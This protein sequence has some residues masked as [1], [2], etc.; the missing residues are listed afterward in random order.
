MPDL[1]AMIDAVRSRLDGRE[2]EVMMVLGSGLGALADEMEDAVR[3]AYGDI[4]GFPQTTVVGHAG[5][6]VVGTLE[7]VPAA[8]LQ[9]RFHL[10]EGHAPA[11]AALPVRLM[12]GLGARALIVTNAAGALNPT[13]EAGDLMLIDDHINLMGTNPLMGG[14]VE[15]DTRFPDM[16]RAYD[17]KL[18]EVAMGVAAREG[19]RLRRGV[20]CA[21]LGP[22]YETPA[23]V[24]MLQHL[25]GDAVGMSTV[26][27]VITARAM[28]V[29]VLGVSLISNLAAGISPKPLD[30][31]EVL[32]AAE[33]ARSRF[34]SLVR[35]VLPRVAEHGRAVE[36][37]HA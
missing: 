13:F 8:V 25:G 1:G 33:Q 14:L 11:L 3:V 36:A 12:K 30:H 27:E 28:G 31:S 22:S 5:A 15:G 23:E 29:P 37:S 24:R 35:G 20:Y 32:E 18:K 10:Y 16:T 6:L 26:P 17:P 21:V 9:G 2:P 34:T 7:G 4:P 19:V